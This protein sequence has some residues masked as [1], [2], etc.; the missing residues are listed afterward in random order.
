MKISALV[1]EIFR[2]E[3]CVKYATKMTDDAIH[4]IQYSLK[5]IN[6]AILANWDQRPLKLCRLLV[7]QETHLWLWKICSH[8]NSLFSSPHP[9]DFNMSGIFSSKN[10][11]WSKN[12]RLAY[13]Y[14]CWIMHTRHNSQIW[15]WTLKVARN[16]LNVGEAWNPVCCHGNTTFKLVL[17]S[18]FSRMLLQ[19]IKHLWLKLAEISFV[20]VFDQNYFGWVYEKTFNSRKGQRTNQKYGNLVGSDQQMQWLPWRNWTQKGWPYGWG[21]L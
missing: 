7:L 17:S 20:V 15:K 5:N 10:A 3:K 21:E 6:R 8:G 12:R 11:T 18:T 2:F 14:A 4:S 13:L 16:V 9:L 1:S 19:R